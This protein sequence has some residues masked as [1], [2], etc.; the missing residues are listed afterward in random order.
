MSVFDSTKSGTFK[1][2]GNRQAQSY[3]SG[4][5]EGEIAQETICFSQNELTCISG[6]SFIAVDQ[7]SDVGKDRFSGIVGLSPYQAEASNMPAFITQAE[8][9]FSFYLSRGDGSVGSIV[10]G[11]YDLDQY[12]KDGSTE[13]DISWIS[14]IED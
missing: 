9:V 14:L 8:S 11:G 12:A 7:A 4:S 2:T 13:Q 5:I 10:L 3:G 6:A 1:A